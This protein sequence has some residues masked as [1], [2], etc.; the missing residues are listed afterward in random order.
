MV[1]HE[2][3]T[4]YLSSCKKTLCFCSVPSLS[5]EGK[6]VAI[7]CD[8]LCAFGSRRDVTDDFDIGKGFYTL[9][10]GEWHGEEEFVVLTSIEGAGGDIEVELLGCDCFGSRWGDVLQRC[11]NPL[12]FR[13][14]CE[15]V[16][17]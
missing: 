6:F 9:V 1:R 13:G 8:E 7:A 14:K 15:G 3:R 2:L 11:D 4:P 5:F 10:V 17:C 12:D 16:R